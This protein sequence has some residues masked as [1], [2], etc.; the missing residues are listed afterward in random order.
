MSYLFISIAAIILVSVAISYFR[1]RE[2][3]NELE[4][5][6]QTN[7]AAKAIAD[8]IN[9]AVDNPESIKCTER[10]GTLYDPLH[11]E[12]R[13]RVENYP[14]FHFWEDY[15]YYRI[16]REKHYKYSIE[17]N[18]ERVNDRSYV[19]DADPQAE[20]KKLFSEEMVKTIKKAFFDHEAKEKREKAE[21]HAKTM[22]AVI[23][24]AA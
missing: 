22:D 2:S 5:F 17:I 23:A 19:L 15:K 20:I 13:F 1:K 18:D 4:N 6:K 11:V 21:E 8:A 24:G 12:S 14:M 10:I 7:Q 9:Y 16:G 3:V